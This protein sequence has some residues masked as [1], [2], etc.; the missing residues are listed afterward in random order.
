VRRYLERTE[1]LTLRYLRTLQEQGLTSIIL[2]TSDDRLLR[3]EHDFFGLADRQPSEGGRVIAAEASD[4][5]CSR[6]RLLSAIFA[7]LSFAATS[8]R[9][10]FGLEEPHRPNSLRPS[11]GGLEGVWLPAPSL[12]L[13]RPASMADAT[14][15][16]ASPGGLFSSHPAP[17]AMIKTVV[18]F[19]VG[20]C[21]RYLLQPKRALGRIYSRGFRTDGFPMSRPGSPRRY[22]QAFLPTQLARESGY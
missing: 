14:P 16:R 4:V 17:R 10:P 11:P 7:G 5:R 21:R 19:L 8:R 18:S 2:P 3:R 20:E 12:V 22:N 9:T 6:L 13:V 1:F 15:L